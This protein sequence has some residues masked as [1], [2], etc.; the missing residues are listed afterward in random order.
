[1]I[2][3]EVFD[4]WEISNDWD[5][6]I[7]CNQGSIWDPEEILTM[8]FAEISQANGNPVLS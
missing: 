1:M 8:P 6:F 5:V 4:V 2:Q 7:I 3:D